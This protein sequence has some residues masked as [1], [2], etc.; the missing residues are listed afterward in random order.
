[1]HFRRCLWIG[2]ARCVWSVVLI[3][4]RIPGSVRCWSRLGLSRLLGL[5]FGGLMRIGRPV[6]VHGMMVMVDWSGLKT[7]REAALE[8]E[9]ARLRGELLRYR[10]CED[11]PGLRIPSS[12][13][14]DAELVLDAPLPATV[15]LPL[16]ARWSFGRSEGCLDYR[17]VGTTPVGSEKHFEVAYWATD[18]DLRHD[19]RHFDVLGR[20]HEV[21]VEKLARSIAAERERDGC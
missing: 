3:F 15:E 1:M 8:F 11:Y 2:C 4:R 16:V 17:V 18:E 6:H 12:L 19:G 20:L 5:G 21:V 14:A 7:P 9:N 10:G 13:P